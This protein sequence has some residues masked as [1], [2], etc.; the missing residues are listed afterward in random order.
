MTTSEVR[1][2]QRALNYFSARYLKGVTPI[3]VDGRWGRATSRRVRWVKFYLGYAGPAG[4]QNAATNAEF[5]AR[6]WHPRSVLRSTRQRVTRGA[7]RRATQRRSWRRRHRAASTTRDV[8]RVDG[9]PCARWMIPYLVWARA[10]GWRGTLVSGFRTPE[11]SDSLC[12]AM[13]GAPRCPGRCAGRSSNHS[14]SVTPS[15]ALD[16]S[17]YVTFGELMQRC[18]LR[19]RIFNALGARDPVHFSATGN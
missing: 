11:Y 6:L 17:D 3:M 2:L 1:R 13:C 16:V 7:R 15:G 18:P 12:H 9:V 10:H 14:G 4:E 5:T 8:G 19:P